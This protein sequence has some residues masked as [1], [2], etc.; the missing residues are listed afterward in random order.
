M[1]RWVILQSLETYYHNYVTHMLEAELQRRVYS[2]LSK[3]GPS[4][5]TCSAI[6]GQC[7]G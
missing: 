6:S 5:P 2:S 7:L 3:A 1:R 4:P